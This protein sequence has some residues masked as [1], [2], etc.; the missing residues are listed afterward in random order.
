MG[1]TT[2]LYVIEINVSGY[3]KK[4]FLITKSQMKKDTGEIV[5]NYLSMLEPYNSKENFIN[6]FYSQLA[7][8]II[9]DGIA[10][11]PQDDI[12]YRM[13]EK[14]MIKYIHN[15]IL[16]SVQQGGSIDLDNETTINISPVEDMTPIK[17]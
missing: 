4:F 14:Y 1:G 17:I 10:I 7:E 3:F 6:S 15:I 12:S 16:Q 2:S 9:V 11:S 8:L 5:I 13:K